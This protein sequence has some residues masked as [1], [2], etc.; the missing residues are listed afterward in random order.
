[1]NIATALSRGTS[2]LS[3]YRDIREFFVTKQTRSCP[4]RTDKIVT[5][6]KQTGLKF[7]QKHFRFFLVLEIKHVGLRRPPR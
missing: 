6:I 2:Q 7:Q 3:L 5:H 4:T 1:M